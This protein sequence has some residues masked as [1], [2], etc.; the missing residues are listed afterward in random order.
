MSTD[1][2]REILSKTSSTWVANKQTFWETRRK[3]ASV[4]RAEQEIRE[5]GH[6]LD[7]V[8]GNQVF[9]AEDWLR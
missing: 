6:E 9:V 1:Y 5:N 2:N 8:L 3:M 7:M 4:T